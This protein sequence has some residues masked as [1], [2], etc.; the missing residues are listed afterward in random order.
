[1]KR[2]FLN[3][4]T[5]VT[6]P[7]TCM[8]TSLWVCVNTRIEAELS[9]ILK[10]VLRRVIRVYAMSVALGIWFNSDGTPELAKCYFV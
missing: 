4:V 7:V 8:E 1:M 10:T 9:R 2:D 6:K 5:H 3:P